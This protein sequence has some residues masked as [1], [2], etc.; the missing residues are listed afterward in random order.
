MPVSNRIHFSALIGAVMAVLFALMALTVSPA[1]AFP[2]KL[3]IEDFTNTSCGPCASWEPYFLQMLG[4]LQ[5]EEYQLVTFHVNWPGP[6]DIWFLANEDENRTRWSFYGV[7]GVPSYFADGVK[8]EVLQSD[9]TYQQVLQRWIPYVQN[10]ADVESPLQITIAC[11]AIGDSLHSTVTIA[12][13]SALN[14]LTLQVALVEN[15]IQYNA[16]NGIREHHDTMI[17]M[18]P[19]ANGTRFNIAAGGQA[20]FSF[21]SARN[22]G[23]HQNALENLSLVAWI[24]ATSHEVIQTEC[25]NLRITSP[26]IALTEYVISDEVNGD[27]D[28]RPEPGETA[29]V[30][31]S[32]ENAQEYLPAE[33]FEMDL[34]ADDAGI[35]IVN[36]T[37]NLDAL[38]NGAQADNSGDPFSFRVADDF[39]AHPVTFHL[40]LSAQPG[41]FTYEESFTMMIGWPPFLVVGAT[42][43][44][45]AD[46]LVGNTF[47]RG[48]IP[49]ADLWD[50]ANL[51]VPPEDQLSQYRAI[52]WHTFNNADPINDYEAGVL[53]G[54]LDNGGTLIMAS[55]TAGD[56]IGNHPLFTGY[57]GVRIDNS[58][59]PVRNYVQGLNEDPQFQGSN[60]FLI[61]GPVG[62]PTKTPSFTPQAG[63]VGVLNYLDGD[64][65]PL[66]IAAVKHETATYKTL[67]LGFP[68]ESISGRLR[69][70]SLNSFMDRVWHWVEG[71]DLAVGPVQNTPHIF[72]LEAAYPNPFNSSATLRY[73][74]PAAG[75][76]TMMI[77]DLAGRNVGTLLNGVAPA[78]VH[79]LSFNAGKFGLGTGVYYVR[80]QADGKEQTTRLLYLK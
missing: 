21:V 46:A 33:Q 79:N 28:G 56:I 13:N 60:L 3:L 7:N 68:I 40:T 73:S 1:N 36:G 14:T 6:N 66:G 26:S 22:A 50:R 44:V 52:L 58:G 72:A 59:T 63:A 34:T 71:I 19:N 4:S 12:S 15:L 11:S 45:N 41:D 74:L 69:S 18:L 75:S 64:M 10:R 43:N 5:P 51:G 20:S 67:I 57:M 25:Y 42:G 31:V 24:Q 9:S 76:A 30:I 35:Q 27:G 78:G 62:A 54:Y 2:R 38:Q 37:F 77:Y 47:G 17:D 65:N 80:L 48:T 32:V 61:G 29:Q 53:M 16:P 70:D 8:L 49:Y 55:P 39:V 23:P